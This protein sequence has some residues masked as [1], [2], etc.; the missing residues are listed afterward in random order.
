ML[1]AAV[2]ENV[3]KNIKHMVFFILLIYV[4]IFLCSILFVSLRLLGFKINMFR[5]TTCVI[6]FHLCLY[7]YGYINRFFIRTTH[8]SVGTEKNINMK[9][10][11]VSDVHIGAV[12]S[13]TKFLERMVRVINEQNAD[14][15]LFGG[16]IMETKVRHF[17]S[18]SYAQVF[19]KI[20]AKLGVYAVLGNHEYYMGR[21]NVEEIVTFLREGCGMQV[22]LDEHALVGTNLLLVGR[23]DGGHNRIAMR[24]KISEILKNVDVADNFLLVLD[25]SPKYF[26]EAMANG[27][28]LQLSGHTHNG[29]MFPFNLLVKFFYEKPYGRL[30]RL[31]STLLVS[32]G[33]G[34]WGPPIKVF[35]KPEVVV[36]DI[37]KSKDEGSGVEKIK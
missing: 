9:V 32:S 33:V 27:A 18:S 3:S 11:F 21:S 2:S 16:D 26:S 13:S 19:R 6:F 24:K 12:G 8:Y 31:N 4:L 5:A 17:D 7:C 37:G 10:V 28:D 1:L 14:L 23:L 35:S 30:E 36:V 34:T 22:L 20:E 29:Q 25:H 15:V